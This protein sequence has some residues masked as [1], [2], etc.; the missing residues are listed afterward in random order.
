MWSPTGGSFQDSMTFPERNAQ[1]RTNVLFNE[2]ADEAV[3]DPLQLNPHPLQ[4][5]PFNKN[6]VREFPYEYVCI[7]KSSLKFN[8]F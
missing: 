8:D 7:I 3:T 2:I 5:Q 6:M 1:P 4:V